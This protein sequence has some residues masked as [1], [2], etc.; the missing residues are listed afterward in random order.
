MKALKWVKSSLKILVVYTAIVSPRSE[1]IGLGPFEVNPEFCENY[2]NLAGIMN[3][4][5]SINW[6][7][8]GAPGFVTGLLQRDN[9]V[10]EFCNFLIRIESLNTEDAIFEAAEF[11]NTLMGNKFDDELNLARST[12]DLAHTAY[13]FEEG[14][15]NKSQM[16][17][18]STARELNDYYKTVGEY[19]N[20]N[21]RDDYGSK[22]DVRTQNQREADLARLISLTRKKAVLEEAVS[23]PDLDDKK[24]KVNFQQIYEN[25]IQP[26][27]VQIELLDEKLDYHIGIVEEIGPKVS[28]DEKDVKLFLKDF[29]RIEREGLGFK[30][31]VRTFSEDTTKR[32]AVAKVDETDP[33]AARTELKT[34][35]VTQ[36]YQQI[37]V[38]SNTEPLDEFQ[39]K[40][41]ERWTT[42]TRNQV[43][44]GEER[45]L[46]DKPVSRIELEFKDMSIECNPRELEESNNLEDEDPEYDRKLDRA[47]A[48]CNESSQIKTDNA[49]GLLNQH[50]EEYYN[51]LEERNELQAEIWTLESKHLGVARS[52]SQK[53]DTNK[54]TGEKEIKRVEVK[55]GDI[56]NVGAM[57]KLQLDIEAANL[58]ANNII[59][60]QLTKSN[61]MAQSKAEAEKSRR[62]ELIL[63]EKIAEEARK[64]ATPDNLPKTPTKL[65]TGAI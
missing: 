4:F 1:A 24:D 48:Q 30:S 17:T 33:L 45:A 39:T 16:L 3:A 64:T 11:G 6:P 13:N 41:G 32:E 23:C 62:D 34:T 12:M 14:E 53:E 63:K 47:I 21:V 20:D 38:K 65:R 36:E 44:S 55:C 43:V 57:Q 2:E 27:E 15:F 5:S 35:S 19:Y 18:Q 22:V 51:V 42:W 37:I 28:A 9:P 31:T 54:F 58:E 60:E 40:W 8:T 7:T 59:A 50:A 29:A 25:D 49:G 56:T 61:M 46:L 10:I 52:F 26:K